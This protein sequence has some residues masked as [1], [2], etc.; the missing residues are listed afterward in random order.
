MAKAWMY[1]GL[2]RIVGKN[3]VAGARVAFAE[4]LKADPQAQLDADL[5]T[6]EA[7]SLWQEVQANPAAATEP[8]K[9]TV[10]GGMQCTPVVR[11]VQTRRPVPVACSSDQPAT[12]AELKYREFGSTQWHTVQMGSAGGKWL[13]TIPCSATDLQGKLSWYVNAIDPSGELIDN[14]G[15][16]RQPVEMQVVE[17]TSEP[18]PAYPD[19]DP[20]TRCGAASECPPEMLG[21]PA[22]PGTIKPDPTRGN[23]EAGERCQN[24]SQCSTGLDCVS[25]EC[26]PPKSCE[27]DIDCEHG[28]CLDLLCTVDEEDTDKPRLDNWLGL[29]FAADLAL[30][31]GDNVCQN[32]DFAC[33]YEDGSLVGSNGATFGG[34]N[35]SP[36][37]VQ[38]GF[39]FGTAR[40][41]VSYERMLMT[42]LG[43]EA[44]LGFA[45]GGAPSA[46]GVSFLPIHAEAR[47]K[48]WFFG[49]PSERVVSPYLHIG[50][51]LGQVDAKV[52]VLIAQDCGTATGPCTPTPLVDAYQQMGVGFVTLGGGALLAIGPNYGINLNVNAQYMLPKS[53]FVLQPAAGFEYGF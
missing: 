6:P 40:L 23:K 39:A 47:G 33:F 3:D 48:Y 44:R 42:N 34:P 8:P 37:N 13:G 53:G 35:T 49:P 1:V 25:G 30:V 31:S 24:S 32:S 43:V 45:F 41:L 20:P 4:A 21:T 50:G 22:C 5:E 36:G 15:A 27:T 19:Q 11:E 29:H 26:Q 46:T 7:R 9:P 16:Q 2:V 17:S 51:G 12:R 10:L 28:R 14:Y 38:S 18:A 52:E